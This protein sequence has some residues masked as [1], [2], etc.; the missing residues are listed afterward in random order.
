MDTPP[1][2]LEIFEVVT[3]SHPD[4]GLRLLSMP[5]SI[6]ALGRYTAI[7]LSFAENLTIVYPRVDGEET[8][9]VDEWRI[10]VQRGNSD[11][12][13][14][15]AEKFVA[16]KRAGE[17]E[18]PGVEPRSATYSLSK[19][20]FTSISQPIK[21]KDLI[22]AIIFGYRES[23]PEEQL[24]LANHSQYEMLLCTAHHTRFMTMNHTL[25]W[26]GGVRDEGDAA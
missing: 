21:I 18:V 24:H 8:A 14:V 16:R 20:K 2:P 1:F 12:F 13:W 11:D 9:Y 4:T 23:N 10:G 15:H 6:P 5:S 7:R 25:G 22:T 3:I 19:P 17:I 26:E